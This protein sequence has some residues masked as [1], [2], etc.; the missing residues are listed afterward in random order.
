MVD[1]SKPQFKRNQIEEALARTIKWQSPPS[2]EFRL[3]VKRL[4]DLD[5]KT[6]VNP[7]S[8]STALQCHAFFTEASPGSGFDV[9]FSSHDVLAVYVA[10]K[11]LYAGFPQY[12]AVSL[13]RGL[14]PAL[15]GEHERILSLPPSDLLDHEPDVDLETA[16]AEGTLVKKLDGLVCLILPTDTYF[17]LTFRTI[18]DRDANRPANICRGRD[19]L[20]RQIESELTFGNTPLL[21][22]LVNPV[23]RLAYWLERTE[24]ARRGRR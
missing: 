12:R 2:E 10:L 11:L 3:D 6:P 19:D 20:M 24:P 5:R 16:I 1:T 4:L 17:G 7:R 15:R 9:L 18:E 8:L 13:M 21:I 14:R 23:H 22:E